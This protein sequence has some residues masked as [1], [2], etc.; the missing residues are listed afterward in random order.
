ME[1]SVGQRTFPVT[2]T[3]NGV[4]NSQYLISLIHKFDICLAHTVITV[5]TK[6]MEIGRHRGMI[7]NEHIAKSSNSYEKVKTFKCLNYIM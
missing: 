7:P 3:V 4:S 6:Y 2:F 5:Q 1:V